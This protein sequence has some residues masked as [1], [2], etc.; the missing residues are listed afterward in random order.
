MSVESAVS[1]DRGKSVA[2]RASAV[3]YGRD[4]YVGLLQTDW[5]VEE[6]KPAAVKFIVVDQNG[7][8]VPGVAVKAVLERLET[9]A[10]R[11]KGAGDAYPA[12]YEKEWV[13][14]QELDLTSGDEGKT[15]E[16]TPDKPGSIRITALVTRYERSHSTDNDKEMG[17]R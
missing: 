8:P 9:K 12:Q 5:V 4:R 7:T 11:V 16:V 17:H 2:D 10:A 1:D 13:K 14:I 6:G 15:F 3:Y